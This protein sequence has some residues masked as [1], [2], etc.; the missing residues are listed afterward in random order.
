MPALASWSS[1][2]CPLMT[3]RTFCSLMKLSVHLTTSYSTSSCS[4]RSMEWLRL[5]LLKADLTSMSSAPV[6][7]LRFQACWVL[8]IRTAIASTHERLHRHSY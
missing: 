2:S 3:S 5:E 7:F 4:M 8:L 6:M 1:P